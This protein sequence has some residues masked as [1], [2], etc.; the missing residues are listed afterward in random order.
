MY[1]YRCL[2]VFCA[3]GFGS[4]ALAFSFSALAQSENAE[5]S[6]RTYVEM[7][8]LAASESVSERVS[9]SEIQ[10]DH[11]PKVAP[12]GRDYT[13]DV[14][15]ETSVGSISCTLWAGK[16]PATT[17]NFVAL[18]TGNPGWVDESGKTHLTPYYEEIPFSERARGAYV[19]LGN[20]PE[21]TGF[22]VV[23]ERCQTHEPVAGT[24]VMVQAFPGTASASFMLLARDMPEFKGMYTVFGKCHALPLIEQL[25]KKKAVLKRVKI[26]SPD[27]ISR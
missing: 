26:L 17:L 4:G 20:R 14:E 6:D 10:A 13:V 9:E 24:I 16:H 25:T 15:L 18:A 8:S 11:H 1:F 19:V 23:D 7:N 22:Y 12:F 2:R 3:L 27:A 21:G 5:K